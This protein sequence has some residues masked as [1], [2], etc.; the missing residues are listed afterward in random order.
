M[1]PSDPLNFPQDQL[2]DALD[3]AVIAFDR[4]GRVLRANA[5][6]RADMTA[7]GEALT[8]EGLFSRPLDLIDANGEPLAARDIPSARTLRT[9][10]V[11]R[12]FVMGVRIA[13]GRVA[14]TSVSTSPMR[15]DDGSIVGA[16]CTFAEV[17]KER[18]ARRRIAGVGGAVP[19]ARGDGGRRRVPGPRRTGAALRV[20]EPRGR[21]GAR[22]RTA[23]VL[24]RRRARGEDHAR[25][26]RGTRARTGRGRRAQGRVGAAAH[27]TAPTAP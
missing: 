3:F 26:R 13:D 18:H 1:W 27:A 24:R 5:R 16:I 12:D 15:D 14:W 22:L 2:L 23:G 7:M 20:R 8:S 25:R 17:T 9:G 11:L 6:A 19:A 10:E 4:S 21:G